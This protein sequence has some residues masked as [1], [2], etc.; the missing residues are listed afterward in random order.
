[1]CSRT[2]PPPPTGERPGTSGT[3]PTLTPRD[4]LFQR[5]PTSVPTRTP[6]SDVTCVCQMEEGGAKNLY[7]QS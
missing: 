4:S 7:L 5:L 6:K 1:M 2:A 3:L